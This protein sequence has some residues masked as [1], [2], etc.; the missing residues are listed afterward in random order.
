MNKNNHF[1]FSRR[2]FFGIV[3]AA[4]VQVVFNQ[5]AEAH[6]ARPP[7]LAGLPSPLR[8]AEVQSSQWSGPPG[9]ARYRIEGVAKVTGQKIYARDFRARDMAGWPQQ[10]RMAWVHAA[11]GF[12]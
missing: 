10:E 5:L 9:K 2:T 8:D 6:T 3:G 11:L 12:C 7:L 1:T 4:G